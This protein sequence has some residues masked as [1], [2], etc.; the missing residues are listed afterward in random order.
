M[1]IIIGPE[2]VSSACGTLKVATVVVS[3]RSKIDSDGVCAEQN[4]APSSRKPSREI[5]NVET[6]LF[7]SC[8]TESCDTNIYQ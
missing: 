4:D 7:G 5:T 6:I 8:V 3:P 2:V 1:P